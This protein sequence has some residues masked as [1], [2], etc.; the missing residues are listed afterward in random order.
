MAAPE[1]EPGE[2]D[3]GDYAFM[4]VGDVC[5]NT[6]A[7]LRELGAP[8]GNANHV[9]AS[10]A[11]GVVFFA[12]AQGALTTARVRVAR[13]QRARLRRGTLTPAAL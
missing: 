3:V 12:D 1:L 5:A 6:E 7:A 8:A 11:Y 10:S 9:V 4:R 2:F 13:L